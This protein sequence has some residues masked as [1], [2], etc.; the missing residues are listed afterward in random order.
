[1]GRSVV[2]VVEVSISPVPV[3]TAV[4]VVKPISG[5]GG[6]ILILGGSGGRRRGGLGSEVGSSSLPRRG[7]ANVSIEISASVLAA[8]LG[9]CN[10]LTF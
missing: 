1:M 7:V 6:A 9:E 10:A 5:P 4:T 2:R 8:F 3:T